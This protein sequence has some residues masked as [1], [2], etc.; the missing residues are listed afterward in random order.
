[1]NGTTMEPEGLDDPALLAEIEAEFAE[2]TAEIQRISAMPSQ[3][4]PRKSELLE[5]LRA[6][7]RE[8]LKAKT[9]DRPEWRQKLD[10]TISR[11]VDRLLEDGIVENADGSL[12]FALRGDTIQ[13]EGGP[14]LRGLLDGLSHM[15]TE[16]FPPPTPPGAAQ[17]G[18]SAAS[19]AQGAAP[20]NPLQGLLGGLGQVL[21]GAL[22][23]AVA[24]VGAQ[25]PGGLSK[26]GDT[27][28]EAKLPADGGELKVVVKPAEPA[29]GPAVP[30]TAVDIGAVDFHGEQKVAASFEFD[31]RQHTKTEPEGQA[32]TGP[33]G[34]AGPVGQAGS[35]AGVG[36]PNAFFQQ[37]FA[38]LGQVMRQALTPQPAPPPQPAEPT[39]PAAPAPDGAPQAQGVASAQS[40]PA[41]AQPAPSPFGGLGQLFFDAIQKAFTPP[42]AGTSPTPPPQGSEQAAPETGA[43]P[44][45]AAETTAE[46]TAEAT[47]NEAM[48]V[49]IPQVNAENKPEGEPAPALN[50]D[51]AGLLRQVLGSIKPPPS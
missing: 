32:A 50:V 20:A 29:S 25:V 44:T 34:Q 22:K 2:L 5:A 26:L 36:G 38:G 8:R 15:L 17:G 3:V 24:Q 4:G 49:R 16:K 23:S 7:W 45:Q 19:A 43:E 1:M 11:A 47:S 46:T 48:S 33:D 41:P 35:S 31:S 28:V 12:G 30:G 6:S 13:S 27:T 21:A 37:L 40:A 10:E 42:A 9:G 39:P 51:L 14:L 18:S